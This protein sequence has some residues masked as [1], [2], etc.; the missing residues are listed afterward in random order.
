MQNLSQIK[1]TKAGDEVIS[2][3]NNTE[4][5][6]KNNRSKWLINHFR[7]LYLKTITNGVGSKEIYSKQKKKDI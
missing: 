7:P 1:Q 6:M 3:K 4:K 5:I 2:L